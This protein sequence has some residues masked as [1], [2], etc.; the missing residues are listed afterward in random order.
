MRPDAI[1]FAYLVVLLAALMALWLAN[2]FRRR[3]FLSG[4]AEDRVFRCSRCASVYT[5]DPDV[6]LSRCPQCGLMNESF[7]FRA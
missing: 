2:A 4:P 1:L 7:D 6:D 3:R 5:D